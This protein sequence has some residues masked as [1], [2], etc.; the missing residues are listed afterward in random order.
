MPDVPAAT[1][2]G[3]EI[4]GD[5]GLAHPPDDEPGLAQTE[6]QDLNQSGNI[7]GI[8]TSPASGGIEHGTASEKR[9]LWLSLKDP[10][11]KRTVLI[12]LTA[13]SHGT[14][15]D[16]VLKAIHKELRAKA[17]DVADAG[18]TQRRGSAVDRRRGSSGTA[19][20]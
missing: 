17:K 6:P 4:A 12:N 9:R 19:V 3:T 15:T 8:Q 2:C 13:T 18:R 7:R 20:C 14:I 1:H 10:G 11:A 5:V 16:D